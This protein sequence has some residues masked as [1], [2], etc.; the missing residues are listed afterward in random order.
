[1]KI[2]GASSVRCGFG[3]GASVGQRRH[4]ARHRN[5]QQQRSDHRDYSYHSPRRDRD[6]QRTHAAPRDPAQP[7]RPAYRCASV[8]DHRQCQVRERA[9]LR[10][11]LA[12]IATPSTHPPAASTTA[13]PSPAWR[14]VMWR[15][16]NSAQVLRAAVG[17]AGALVVTAGRPWE[18]TY[19]VNHRA[20]TRLMQEGV[21]RTSDSAKDGAG[22]LWS[23]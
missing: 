7:S 17:G 18:R 23:Y 3:V 11:A 8:L 13:H 6:E 22:G 16:V 10:T 21:R 20:S 15:W 12:V 2:V 14:H 4:G 19:V 5:C 9:T 1:M